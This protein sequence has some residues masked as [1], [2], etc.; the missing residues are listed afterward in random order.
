MNAEIFAKTVKHLTNAAIRFLAAWYLHHLGCWSDWLI[1]QN[2]VPTHLERR[3][4]NQWLD[5]L[6]IQEII[7]W[8]PTLDTCDRCL[9]WSDNSS[10]LHSNSDLNPEPVAPSSAKTV[11]QWLLTWDRFPNTELR[12]YWDSVKGWV[13]SDPC[14]APYTAPGPS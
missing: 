1:T 7:F 6:D 5:Y 8:Q 12:D 3:P 2:S 13:S 9:M 14:D 11:S 4:T 10:L